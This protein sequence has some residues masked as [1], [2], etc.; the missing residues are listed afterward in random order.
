M[1]PRIIVFE[2]LW[3]SQ[4]I[5]LCAPWAQAEYAWLYGLADSWGSFELTSLRV[6][7]GKVAPIRKNF[8][9][10]RLEQILDEFRDK[11]LLFV[12]T[13]DGKRYGHWTNSQKPGRRPPPSLQMRY[14]KFAPPV[15]QEQLAAYMEAKGGKGEANED[16]HTNL[17]ETSMT[18]HAQ[19]KD[20]D[21]DLDRDTGKAWKTKVAQ[22]SPSLCLSGFEE[23]WKIYPKKQAKSRALKAW[24]KIPA[25]EHPQI[26]ADV[27][28]RK[29]SEDWK[30]DGGRFVPHPATYLNERRWEDA[31]A[32]QEP[33]RAGTPEL[34]AQ[35]W[36]N[37][38]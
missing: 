24:N 32:R 5:A 14:A 36:R 25:R 6:I 26:L 8:T 30:R 11:G 17:N 27:Q 1:P 20:L 9:L 37:R 33:I 15:P 28:F 19:D 34:E 38:K 3:A 35:P 21:K 4:K 13:Q 10:E 31:L 12:W 22:A 18:P 16:A 29:Q 23:F 7:F 2:A